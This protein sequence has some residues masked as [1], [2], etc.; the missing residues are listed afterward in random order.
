MRAVRR[1]TRRKGGKGKGGRRSSAY[2]AQNPDL[3]A[4][5]KGRSGKG[6]GPAGAGKGPASAAK[7][8]VNEDLMAEMAAAPG[9]A[10]C[11]RHMSPYNATTKGAPSTEEGGT[12]TQHLPRPGWHGR[13]PARDLYV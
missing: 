12:Q 10:T 13:G 5:F 7:P 9:A 1:F 11:P 8:A 4:L 2:V 6:K 3:E